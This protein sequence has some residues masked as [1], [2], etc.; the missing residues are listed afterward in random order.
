M[1]QLTAL[2]ALCSISSQASPTTQSDPIA[3]FK[4]AYA[5]RRGDW[6]TERPDPAIQRCMAIL[7]YDA[8]NRLSAGADESAIEAFL[9]PY[10]SVVGNE[11]E[12]LEHWLGVHLVAMGSIRVAGIYVS[13]ASRLFAWDGA[14]PVS[15]PSEFAWQYP[16]LV[17][18]HIAEDG[19]LL[20]NLRIEV[21]FGARYGYKVVGFWR[22]GRGY[23][24]RQE[25]RKNWF[26]T[27]ADDPDFRLS[28][29]TL[30]LRALD[31]PLT[32]KTSMGEGIF[33]RTL[34]YKV[35]KGKVTLVS[36]VPGMRAARAVDA[37]FYAAVKAKR[38]NALQRRFRSLVGTEIPEGAEVFGVKESILSP[39]SARVEFEY[40]RRFTFTLEKRAGLWQVIGFSESP[41]AKGP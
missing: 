2:V 21:G 1:T 32:L 28:A 3:K 17:K 11:E 38:P 19:T 31:N 29:S 12:G 27:D 18:P 34:L 10:H 39:T 4:A 16:F 36:S 15:V 25:L 13:N 33:P 22:H 20:A 26:L 6:P 7:A 41:M 8:L 35:A 40:D 24:K 37:W 5:K 9:K 30:R 23:E 14:K